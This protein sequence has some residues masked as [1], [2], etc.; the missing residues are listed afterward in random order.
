MLELS[1]IENKNDGNGQSYWGFLNIDDDGNGKIRLGVEMMAA[2]NVRDENDNLV[3]LIIF[4][5]S[6]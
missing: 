1:N 3:C 2:Q 4:L 6:L 5:T